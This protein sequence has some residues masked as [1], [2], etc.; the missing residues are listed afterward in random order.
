MKT[1]YLVEYYTFIRYYNKLVENNVKYK[2][3]KNF[4]VIPEVDYKR[5]IELHENDHNKY[6]L[7]PPLTRKESSWAMHAD[8]LSACGKRLCM[9]IDESEVK[10][11][12]YADVMSLTLVDNYYYQEENKELYLLQHP[13]LVFKGTTAN[14]P[15]Y[16]VMLEKF[17]ELGENGLYYKAD[18]LESD[19]PEYQITAVFNPRTLEEAELLINVGKDYPEELSNCILYMR[20]NHNK[21]F[22]PAVLPARREEPQKSRKRRRFKK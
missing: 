17:H 3:C 19:K 8:Y 5:L 14:N 10:Y 11:F 21:N 20:M 1:R 9:E 16:Q 6:S 2:D 12:P 15:E 7:T 13:S 22:E 18:S 4:D